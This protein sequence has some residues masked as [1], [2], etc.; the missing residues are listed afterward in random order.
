MFKNLSLII[1]DIDHF[2]KVNDTYG[3]QA[4]DDVIKEIAERISNSTR[5]GGSLCEIWR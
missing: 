2:K 4:G 3:H 5:D 1:L